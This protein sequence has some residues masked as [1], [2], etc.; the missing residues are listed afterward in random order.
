MVLISACLFHL[1][2]LLFIASKLFDCHYGAQNG[3]LCLYVCST[4]LLSHSYEV[5]D[6]IIIKALRMVLISA[7][8]FHLLFS[9]SQ[10]VS[11]L[12]VIGEFRMVLMSACLFQPVAILFI[13]C[14]WSD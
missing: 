9:H 2:A 12:I 5:S 13:A 11:G 7:N 14:V 1:V 8:L 4:L 6:L 10:L 3:D